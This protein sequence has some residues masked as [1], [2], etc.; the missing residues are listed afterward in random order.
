MHLETVQN[1]AKLPMQHVQLTGD[2]EICRKGA[3]IM[4]EE[5]TGCTDRLL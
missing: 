2:A 4:H 5:F 1:R 3:L